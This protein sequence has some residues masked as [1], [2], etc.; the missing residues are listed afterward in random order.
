MHLVMMMMVVIVIALMVMIMV[1]MFL[2]MAH[3]PLVLTLVSNN[4]I[5]LKVICYNVVFIH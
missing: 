5:L 1:G 3:F 2:R 4:N